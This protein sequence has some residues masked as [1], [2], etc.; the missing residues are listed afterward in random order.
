MY[1][2]NSVLLMIVHLSYLENIE[3]LNKSNLKKQ[4]PTLLMF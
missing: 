1:L 4:T 2:L 3:N